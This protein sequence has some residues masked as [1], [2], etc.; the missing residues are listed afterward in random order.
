MVQVNRG[1]GFML[2][3]DH[4]STKIRLKQS[5]SFLKFIVRDIFPVQIY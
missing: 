3:E 1:E 5:K 4:D 2:K